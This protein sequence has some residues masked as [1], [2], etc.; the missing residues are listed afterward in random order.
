VFGGSHETG[1]AHQ[2]FQVRRDH[3]SIIGDAGPSTATGEGRPAAAGQ[4]GLRAGLRRKLAGLAAR[5]CGPHLKHGG[6]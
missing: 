6:P 5:G 4:R 1:K 2:V 3:S